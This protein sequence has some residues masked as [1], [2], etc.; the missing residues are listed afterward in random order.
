M[1]I[2][3]LT[4]GIFSGKMLPFFPQKVENVTVT[5]GQDA[6]LRCKVDNL[7]NYKVKKYDAIRTVRVCTV[8]QYINGTHTDKSTVWSDR[9]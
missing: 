6:V 3:L 5:I 1:H 8:Q 9:R 7:K 2:N 4:N